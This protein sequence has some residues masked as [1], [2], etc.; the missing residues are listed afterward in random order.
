M[1]SFI[2]GVWSFWDQNYS[3]WRPPHS[4]FISINKCAGTVSE[5]LAIAIVPPTFQSLLI[6]TSAGLIGFST[7]RSSFTT[8]SR[9]SLRTFRSTRVQFRT[10][11]TAALG[12]KIVPLFWR[13]IKYLGSFVPFGYLCFQILSLEFSINFKDSY[14]WA[15]DHEFSVLTLT[16][17]NCDF[18]WW[19]PTRTNFRFCHHFGFEAA[20]WYWHFVSVLIRTRRI[21]NFMWWYPTRTN[22]H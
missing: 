11:S 17:K 2:A 8:I 4:F 12:I 20:A 15:L 14:L 5:I 19:Y 16:R 6:I 22:Q 7:A 3:T 13:V 9:I 21:C 1:C 10:S 18:M